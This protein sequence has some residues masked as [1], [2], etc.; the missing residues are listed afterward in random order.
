MEGGC[1]AARSRYIAEGEPISSGV[2]HCETCRAPH[3]RPAPF[4]WRVVCRLSLHPRRP[5]DYASSP[6]SLAALRRDAGLL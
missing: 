1:L 2:C 5:V 4:H 3:R 6:A